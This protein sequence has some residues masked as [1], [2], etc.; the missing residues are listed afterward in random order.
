MSNAPILISTIIPSY[1]RA[2]TV[3]QTIESELTCQNKV[4]N[5]ELGMGSWR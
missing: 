2:D 1:N 5:R 4:G 3:G